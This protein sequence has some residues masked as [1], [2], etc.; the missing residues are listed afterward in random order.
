[1][2]LLPIVA[3]AY[4]FA[5][6]NDDGFTIYYNYIN[7]GT[8][9]EVTYCGNSNYRSYN[10]VVVIPEEVT[11]MN[12][13]RKVTS[14][15]YSAFWSCGLTSVT[16]PNSVTSIGNSAFAECS[17]LTS[18][19]IPNSVTSIGGAAFEHCIGLTSVTIPNGVTS[20]G[21]SAFY[22]CSGLTSITIPNSVTSIG[23]YAFG[24]CSGLT[25][26]TIGNSVT[27]IGENAFENCG[28]LKKV[29]VSDIAAWC[30]IKFAS[31]A[32]NP[33]YHAHHLYSD[34]NTEIKDLVIP[35]GVTSIGYSAFYRCSGLT[36]VTIPNSV[37]SIG[38]QAFDGV[39]IPTVISLIENPF[40][41]TGKTSNY[42][43]FSQNTFLN[44]T[45]YV[46]KGT[47]EKYKATDGWKDFVF[48]EEGNGSGGDTPTTQKC[49][50]PTI[51]YENGKL[52]YYCETEGAMCQS[53]ITDADI[54]SYSSNEVQLTVTYNISVYAT[55]AGYENSE[56]A[57]AT[58]CWIDKEPSTEGITDGVAQI[59]SKAV[60]IQSEGGILRVEGVDDGTQ[61]A[62]YTPDGKQ[63][64]SA[65]SRNGAALVGTNIQPGN[66]A[67]VKIGEKAVKVI[68]K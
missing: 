40:T 65:I 60:L 12:R 53:T 34:E 10:G 62:V 54:K 31:G 2:I 37:T 4:D 61:V 28:Q 13:T 14:I 22:Q 52:T 23:G 3:S 39:D 33:L 50:K 48:I 8:E 64:G 20:I 16:I 42:R 9:L 38:N 67:I 51:S 43:T 21:Y 30:G 11:Y 47:I 27:S 41:I 6:E 59:P 29:I 49:E 25:S 15:G 45:L 24:E 57:T 19:T 46:P 56:T 1:M 36:S 26:V 35:N 58:L 44:A 63:A 66:T 32:A 7:N 5:V 68:I 17:G 55:K 18:I